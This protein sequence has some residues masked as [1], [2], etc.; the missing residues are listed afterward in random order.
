M[1]KFYAHSGKDEN[2]LDGQPLKDHLLE[3]AQRASALARGACPADE[4]LAA[5]AYAA[6]LLH[7][8]GKYQ[9]EWQQYLR[10]SVA[11]RRAVSV[12]HAIHGAAHA[13][14][15]LGHQALCLA[16]LGHHAGLADF[17]KTQN[18]LE[19][20]H[21]D[22]APLVGK[23]LLA[24]KGER[25]DFPDTVADHPLDAED[26]SSRRGYEFWTRFLFSILVDADRLM[27]ERFDTKEERKPQKLLPKTLLGKLDRARDRLAKGKKGE[28]AALR[29]RVFDECAKAGDE[30]QGFF[31][32]TVPTGG[33]KTFS[34]MAFAL[35]HAKRHNLRRVIVV[36]PF[37]SIIEQNAREYRQVFGQDV[38]IE[39]HS[40]VAGDG[41]I[42]ESRSMRNPAEQATENWDAPVIITTSVQ[43]LETLLSASPRR[44]RK[45]HNIA[46]S[47]VLFD[48]A[49]AMPPHILN[50]LL[51]TFRELTANY[52]VSFVFS[53][54]TQPAFR[55]SGGLTEGLLPGELKPILSGDLPDQLFRD[56]RRVQYHV[57]L[58]NPWSWDQLVT[59][60]ADA[61]QALCVLNTRANARTVW[62]LLREKV[63][64][65]DGKKA[66]KGVVHLSSAM[67]AQHRLDVLGSKDS[68]LP[69]SVRDRLRRKMPCW[70]VSTQ[71]VEAGVDIDF[72]QVF[73]AL[74]PLDSI[75]QAAGRCNREGKLIEQATEKVRLGDVFVFE[76]EEKGMPKGF[77]SAAAGE[78][79]TI[80]GEVSGEKL[81]TDRA[82]FADYFTTLYNRTSTDATPKGER[83]IQEMRADFLYRAVAERAK[84]ID[85]GGTPVIVPYGEAKPIIRMIRRAGYYDRQSLRRLQRF[86]VN[87]RSFDLGE[88]KNA[89]LAVPL[90]AGKKDGPL[91]LNRAAY[92]S[93]LGVHIAGQATRDFIF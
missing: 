9:T 50:P 10:D 25:P 93:D 24:A 4:V 60:L 22:L 47:V 53:T 33:G 55:R 77:Y 38:V 79:R 19:V 67:C 68:M 13:A 18:D 17:S 89:G 78:T 52:G 1:T 85:D 30:A 65:K 29:N 61:Q 48:E 41:P 58:K 32:L 74:G 35:A 3:V 42:P 83:P 45:L 81:A 36:I 87:V 20:R 49:Q 69:G 90:L 72:P 92:S 34:G 8:L 91:L 64:E 84:V 21:P 56:L 37:L 46:R 70:L 2:L 39:H 71:V 40:A 12:R 73:R 28:L 5:T 26:G 86:I 62:H 63:C 66:A 6:G 75:V 80:L 59:R 82:I 57:D 11:K 76:P 44:C 51:S 88:L 7:D 16:V 27:T 15:E 31:E 43:F 54:A 23:L 14:Y